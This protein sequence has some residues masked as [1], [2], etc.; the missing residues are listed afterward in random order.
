MRKY[1]KSILLLCLG[2]GFVLT[3]HA[4]YYEIANQLPGLIRPALSGSAAYK[5]FVD[6]SYLKGLGSKEVDFINV[7]TSQGFKYKNWFYMGVGIGVDVALGHTN[8]N[9]GQ[10]HPDNNYWNHG[11][12]KTGVM[13]PIFTDFRFNIGNQSK[14]SFYIDAR[15]GASFLMTDNYLAVGDGFITNREYFYFKPSMGVKIPVSQNGKQAV[16]IG[17]TYQLLTANYVWYNS[18]STTIN[19]LGATVSFEW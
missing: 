11:Y 17:V 1:L 14:P 3:S 4:Q 7:S 8:N 10:T 2:L 15:L 6:V 9:F 5:G 18:S 13:I 12:T 19:A 16:D